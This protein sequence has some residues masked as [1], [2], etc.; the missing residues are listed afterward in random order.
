VSDAEGAG[1][2]D[3][4]RYAAFFRSMLQR[5]VYLP[6]AQ[7]EAFFVSLAHTPSDIDAT[8]DAARESLAA[9]RSA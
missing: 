6:P 3:T 9:I 7:F 1:R 4:A 8:V 5:G 2:A